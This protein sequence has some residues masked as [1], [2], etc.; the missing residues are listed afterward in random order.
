MK[1]W[2][3]NI[4]NIKFDHSIWLS[5]VLYALQE[6]KLYENRLLDLIKLYF[7]QEEQE[8]LGN[9]LEEFGQERKTIL[10]VKKNIQIH[11]DKIKEK[12]NSNGEMK[13]LS[14]S[15]HQKS[16]EMMES[17]RR[18]YSELKEKYHRFV[19]VQY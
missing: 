11:V 10:Y 12:V 2:T 13:S 16:R 14:D 7:G 5:E 8:E 18:S 3:E 19:T 6:I 15:D 4:D 9:M 17:F 1:N